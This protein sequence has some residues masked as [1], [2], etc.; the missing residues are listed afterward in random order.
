MGYSLVL[1]IVQ[2]G[3]KRKSRQH[4]CRK[5]A[6]YGNHAAFPSPLQAQGTAPAEH[7][8]ALRICVWPHDYLLQST[9][10]DDIVKL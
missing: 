1:S 8:P 4:S 9:L 3:E 5:Q 6:V 10:H 2:K 7:K